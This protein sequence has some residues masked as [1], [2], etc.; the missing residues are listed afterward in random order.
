MRSFVR[1]LIAVQIHRLNDLAQGGKAKK[2]V[3]RLIAMSEHKVES[4]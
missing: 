1:A 4:T 2:K 3:L